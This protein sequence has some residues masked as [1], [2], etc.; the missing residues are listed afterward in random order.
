[1]REG[2]ER[3]GAFSLTPLTCDQFLLAAHKLRN[4]GT[5]RLCFLFSTFR[6]GRCAAAATAAAVVVVERKK[7]KFCLVEKTIW[8]RR[9]RRRQPSSSS[10]SAQLRS[11]VS[12]LCR[13]I[14]VV[15]C[16]PASTELRSRE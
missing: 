10:M 4:R 8:L 11:I 1:M 12:H 7:K 2:R 16:S 14:V 3:G 5:A 15:T 6:Q 9:R 13:S